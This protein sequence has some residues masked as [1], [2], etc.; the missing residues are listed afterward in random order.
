[1]FLHPTDEQELLTVVKQCKGKSPT[2]YD[3]IDMYVVKKVI[4]HIAKP[5]T[6]ICNTSFETCIF[7]DNKKVTKVIPVYNT[8]EKK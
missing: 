1:M 8:G 5:F 7:P 4:S 6:H 2:G 3:G